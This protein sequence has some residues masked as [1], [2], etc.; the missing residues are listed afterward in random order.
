MPRTLFD[1]GADLLRVYAAT[2]DA[3]QNREW[4]SEIVPDLALAVGVEEWMSQLH[5]EEAAKLDNYVALVKTLEMEAAAARAEAEQWKA[6]AFARERRVKWLK[7]RMLS[8]L[9][10]TGRERVETAT[11]RVLRVQPNGGKAG[12]DLTPL[13]VCSSLVPPECKRVKEEYDVETIRKKLEAGEV[14]D[15][16]RLT[17][18]GKHLRIG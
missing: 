14:L 12:V 9:I 16:A 1:I 7:E 13:E 15:F 11:G 17:E 5:T 10:A 3:E 6:K 4:R 18:R 8:H 2:D